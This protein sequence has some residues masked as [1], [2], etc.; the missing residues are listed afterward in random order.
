L[1]AALKHAIA[2]S[3]IIPNASDLSRDVARY[4]RLLGDIPAAEQQL[5]SAIEQWPG[6]PSLLREQAWCAA[7]EDRKREA[8]TVRRKATAITL[9]DEHASGKAGAG[10]RLMLHNLMSW[11][12]VLFP[13]W[14]VNSAA[15]KQ[16]RRIAGQYRGRDRVPAAG[17]ARITGMLRTLDWG[18]ARSS[19][20]ASRT[21]NLL[22]LLVILTEL[23]AGI[24]APFWAVKIAG[25]TKPTIASGLNLIG[26]YTLMLLSSAATV[27]LT[28]YTRPRVDITIGGILTAIIIAYFA[29]AHPE[30]PS[31]I[32]FAIIIAL[33]IP[34]FL[35]VF[36]Q[37]AASAFGWGAYALVRRASFRHPAAAMIS[38][39]LELSSLLDDKNVIDMS[40]RGRCLEIV[41]DVA[42]CQKRAL[43]DPLSYAPGHEDAA[44]AQQAERWMAGTVEAT[45]RLKELILASNT[46]T[47]TFLL[48]RIEEIL[49]IVY[50]ERWKDLPEE[51]PPSGGKRA[52]AWLSITART[53]ITAVLPAAVLLLYQLVIVRLTH[54]FPLVPT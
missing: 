4:Y 16:L 3:E 41:E 29:I 27:R 32:A 35:A 39:L 19:A 52:R 20:L 51:F 10:R 22:I 5:H 14:G 49:G 11:L 36:F 54:G 40:T 24:T 13:D 12:L 15:Q 7:A 50:A 28:R 44:R 25:F 21:A 1:E 2:A 53:L 46:A 34:A 23:A 43:L 6:T 42:Q 9:A 30:F 38:G 47:V 37:I 17:R 33:V 45:R 31:Q 8:R 18:M 26:V 48:E